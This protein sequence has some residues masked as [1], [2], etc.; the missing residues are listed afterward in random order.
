MNLLSLFDSDHLKISNEYLVLDFIKLY[1][2]NSTLRDI[3][4]LIEVVRFNY[5]KTPDL[6][7]TMWE[8]YKLK[9]L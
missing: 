5:V 1:A 6:I 2:I 9:E 4:D 3:N 7:E 8:S